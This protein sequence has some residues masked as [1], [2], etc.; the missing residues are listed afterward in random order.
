MD[1]GA[2]YPTARWKGSIRLSGTYIPLRTAFGARRARSSR[3]QVLLFALESAL[4]IAVVL[5][6]GVLAHWFHW[7]L[8]VSALL[9]LLVIVPVALLCGFWQSVVVSLSAVG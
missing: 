4:G 2:L 1:A 9:C 6:I 5:F 7:L 3:S 8:P